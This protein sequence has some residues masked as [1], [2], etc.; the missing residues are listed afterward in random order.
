VSTTGDKLTLN[1]PDSQYLLDEEL[2]MTA[3]QSHV[4]NVVGILVL[5]FGCV[6]CSDTGTVVPPAPEVFVGH[7][8]TSFE[9]S[10]F[11]PCTMNERP[12]YGAGYWL[13]ADPQSG[14]YEQ[15]RKISADTV[16]S[17]SPYHGVIVFV[18]FTGA[19][20]PP[21]SKLNGYGHLGQYVRMITVT[22]VL[23]MTASANDQCND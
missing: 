5:I 18:R 6:S 10:S 11:V 13:E 3:I 9:V 15:Y 17:T 20:S 22:E 21:K 14:F 4:V 2:G 23:E 19:V 7:Y 12:G 16:T 1:I 8:I